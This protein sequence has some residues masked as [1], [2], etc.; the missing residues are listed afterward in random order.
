MKN[1]NLEENDDE[2][3]A[4]AFQDINDPSPPCHNSSDKS[5]M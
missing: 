4:V 3:P 2:E 5:I 1:L